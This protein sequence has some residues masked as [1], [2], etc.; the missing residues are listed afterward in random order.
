MHMLIYELNYLTFY[1]IL[2]D[3]EIAGYE[4]EFAIASI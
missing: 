1:D 4:V 3:R 2:V